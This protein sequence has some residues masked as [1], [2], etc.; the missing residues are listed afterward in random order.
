MPA[1]KAPAVPPTL[2]GQYTVEEA[3]AAFGDPAA[4]QFFCDRQFAVVKRATLCFATTGDPDTG[5]KV[6]SPSLVVWK[7]GRLDY[8]PKA[9]EPWFPPPLTRCVERDNGGYVPLHHMFL[10]PAGDGPFVYA[11]VAELPMFG[12][13]PEDGRVQKS[14]Q[15]FLDAK[16]PRDLW[17]RLGGFPGWLVGFNN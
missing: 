14:A 7:P 3:V 4:A 5:T 6:P 1:K 9:T 12:D 8:H 17:L 15:F 16:L 13:I 10:R 2:Y 11:G